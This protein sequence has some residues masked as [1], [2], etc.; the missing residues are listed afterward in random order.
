MNARIN[1]APEG[2]VTVAEAAAELTRRG[3][4]IT[5]PN[6]SRYLDRNTEIATQKIG[7]YRYVD[8][9]A[10]ILHRSG[11]VQSHIKRASLL[12]EEPA[13][14]SAVASSQPLDEAPEETGGGSGISRAIQEANLKLK[15]LQVRE[16]ERD[17]QL[18]VGELVPAAEVLSIIT[19][20][21]QV[22]LSEFER[23][24]VAMA[25]QFGRPIATAFR[26]V[27][28]EAQAKAADRL[29]RLAQAHLHE[30]VVGAIAAEKPF[31]GE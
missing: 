24:E 9:A 8:L 19:Q 18:A 4:A 28:K 12:A 27:R 31:E 17:E 2:F 7:K 13:Y 10:L 30:S 1:R 29:A 23:A 5:A 20:T 14:A 21:A 25:A 16:A 6:V 26:K 22:L 11:N 15:Q 3:D